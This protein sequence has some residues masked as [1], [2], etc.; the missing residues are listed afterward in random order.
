MSTDTPK[1]NVLSEA[2]VQAVINKIRWWRFPMVI[3]HDSSRFRWYKRRVFRFN[4]GIAIK[5]G[6]YYYPLKADYTSPRGEWRPYR[7]FPGL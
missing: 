4:G 2:V 7:G 5:E 6:D 3:I 1:E